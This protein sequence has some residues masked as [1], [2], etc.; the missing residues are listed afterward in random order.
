M[1]SKLRQK[2]SNCI[3]IVLYGP[4]STGKTTLAKQ[5][6]G[7]FECD[8]V[9][10]FARD[11]LQEKWDKERK[12]CE[13][14]DLIPIAE[15][16]MKLENQLAENAQ[17]LLIC[18]TNLL[19]TKVYSEVYFDG[20]CED[21]LK[22]YALENFY[23]LYILTDIDVPWEKD[24]LRD[25][26][27]EREEM[28]SRFKEELIKHRKPYVVISGNKEER[29]N[30]SV[31][32]IKRIFS[33]MTF[34]E[35][36]KKQITKHGL[37][38][39]ELH[40]QI[41]LISRGVPFVNLHM[42]ATINNGILRCSDS[43]KDELVS[44]YEEKKDDYDLM[45]FVPASGEATRMFKFLFEFLNNYDPKAENMESYLQRSKDESLRKFALNLSKFP[46]HDLVIQ[47]MNLLGLTSENDGS[48]EYL[49]KYIKCLLDA[50]QL[51]FGG[52]PKGLIPFHA[53]E[54]HTSS[55]FEEHL[56][57]AIEYASNGSH[58]KLHFTVS[59]KHRSKFE[60]E[61]NEVT[62]R[63]ESKT[64]SKID[65]DFSFQ[66]P[67][68][69]TIALD[70]NNF[71]FRDSYGKLVFRASGHGALLNNLNSLD[72]D[73]VFIKNVDNVV[74]QGLLKEIS[75]E[76]KLLGGVLI[77]LQKKIFS[78]LIQLEKD[79]LSDSEIDEMLDF[80]KNQLNYIPNSSEEKKEQLIKFLNRPIRVCGMVKNEGQPGGGP[81]WINDKHG[82]SLQIV[83]S[84]QVDLSNHEQE[85]IFRSSTHFNPVDIV[86][87]LKNYK[88]ESFDLSDFVDHE[89]A[90]IS[91]KSKEGRKLK[92][93]ERPGLW[94]GSMAHWIT[95]FVEVPLITFNPVKT[96]VDLLK[97]EHQV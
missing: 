34:T 30:K 43:D 23:H 38:I 35:N 9:P 73:I 3:K 95:V 76:K 82:I 62:Q 50:D 87:G 25:K 70:L 61:F 20:Y 71:P 59:K 29:F 74:K 37:D 53:Y 47:R 97:P 75:E 22:N 1:E 78:Y 63:M 77:K 57:E 56:L 36:D 79:N 64:N 92:A 60:N 69:D 85:S 19:E 10:E 5:L 14:H 26:P 48:G 96:V 39:P 4:E 33:R 86:C 28:F 24:D 81:F 31:E 11:Y 93:L 21:E 72:A 65:V 46:F 89:K 18:D 66:N 58:L 67:S 90:F 51:N 80:A 42:A 45:K 16:Q 13:P 27:N 15:G 2:A 49:I 52:T 12:V 83:E 54:D 68:T 55:P 32:E 7:H 6:A 91:I 17:H 44:Y 88:G 41:D 40:Q 8:W 84:A 94:N